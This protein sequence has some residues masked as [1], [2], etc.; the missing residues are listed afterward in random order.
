[1]SLIID[2]VLNCYHCAELLR[3]PNIHSECEGA[4]KLTSSKDV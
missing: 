4:G 1:M 3:E 2:P